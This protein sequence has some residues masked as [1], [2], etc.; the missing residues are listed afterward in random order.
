MPF[1]SHLLVR[2]PHK[3]KQSYTE[4]CK[5]LEDRLQY[6]HE[7]ARKNSEKHHLA[8]KKE[9]DRVGKEQDLKID[10]LVWVY[11]P[12]KKYGISPK[13]QTFWEK[14]PYRIVTFINDRV[15]Q[16]KEEESGRERI[17]HIDYVMPCKKYDNPQKR[18]EIQ[19]SPLE[20]CGVLP[21]SGRQLRSLPQK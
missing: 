20:Q 12:T 21:S 3:D 16:V 7:I 9:Y 18:M 1:P 4:F 14:V 15:I 8:Q 10:S 2:P 19:L 17:V 6:V 11:N 5:E 13:L